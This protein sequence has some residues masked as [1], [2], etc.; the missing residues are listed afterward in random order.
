MEEPG[1]KGESAAYLPFFQGYMR[2]FSERRLIKILN[3]QGSVS[4]RTGLVGAQT[5]AITDGANRASRPGGL[6]RALS[7]P[8]ISRDC[9]PSPTG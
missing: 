5:L 2:K 4:D 6:R 9:R 1:G 7:S 8:S 3:Q